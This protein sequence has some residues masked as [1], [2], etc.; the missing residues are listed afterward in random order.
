MQANKYKT[1][2]Q[3]LEQKN[4]GEEPINSGW[5]CPGKAG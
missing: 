4:I 2:L 5:G 3:V 1:L